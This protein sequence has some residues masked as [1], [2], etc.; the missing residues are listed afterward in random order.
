M[1]YTE[2]PDGSGR[3]A[4]W[5]GLNGAVVGALLPDASLGTR[6][7]GTASSAY[8][9]YLSGIDFG[10]GCETVAVCHLSVAI[11]SIW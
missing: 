4:C 11:I 3:M 6:C 5:F 2:L 1:V 8:L 7:K 10:I 9:Q